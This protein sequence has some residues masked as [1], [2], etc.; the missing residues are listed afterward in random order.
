MRLTVRFE[1]GETDRL[2]QRRSLRRQRRT[3]RHDCLLVGGTVSGNSG[4]GRSCSHDGRVPVSPSVLAELLPGGP[5]RWEA[6]AGGE[7]GAS[8][9]HDRRTQRYAK[10]VSSER[11]AELAAERDRAVWISR[12]AVPSLPVLDWRQT[13]A[14]A[15]MVT[16]AVAGVPASELDAQ[17]LLEAWPSV[18]SVVRALH[19]LS[20]D[21]CPYDRSLAW[22]MPLAH[23]SV[24]EGRVVVDFLPASLQGTPPAQI[25][26]QIERELPV[27]L[28]Q[29]RTDLVVCHGDLCLPNI[30]VDPATGLVKALIDVGRLG[31]ADPYGDIA[32]LLATAR[33]TWPDEAMARQADRQFAQEYGTQLDPERQDFYLRLDPLTW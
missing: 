32:L 22:M 1:T 26:E 30:L 8:V 14:G 16:Q 4:H 15:C 28:A 23:A 33:E 6:V 13:D 10:V 27:R 18:A 21:R 24:V 25:L 19:D 3:L 17:A 12:T 11:V 29:E 31:T 7:S 5:E 20:A 2:L 9:V